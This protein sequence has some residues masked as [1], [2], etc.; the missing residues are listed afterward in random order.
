LIAMTGCGCAPSALVRWL[1]V[2]ALTLGAAAVVV[3][4]RRRARAGSLG[5]SPDTD[6]APRGAAPTARRARPELT[7]A[8]LIGIA[9]VVAAASLSSTLSLLGL[10][11]GA[12]TATVG[13]GVRPSRRGP[14]PSG[15]PTADGQ[16]ERGRSA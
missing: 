15:R 8:I 4:G 16:S 12:V 6:G 9:V 11:V 5:S 2:A 14:D 7:A 3:V 1:V 10:A 13:L